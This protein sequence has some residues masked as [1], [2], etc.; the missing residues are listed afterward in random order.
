MN[1][2]RFLHILQYFHFENIGDAFDSIGKVWKT[3]ESIT[4][5]NI[6]WCILVLNIWLVAKYWYFSKE[7]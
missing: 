7:A 5:F 4:H 6:E 2:D 3:V 1:C